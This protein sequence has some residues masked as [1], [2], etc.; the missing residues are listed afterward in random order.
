MRIQFHVDMDG[1]LWDA[2]D[3]NRSIIERESK[4]YSPA[5]SSM[6]DQERA[7]FWQNAWK[8]Y[9]GKTESQFHQ[10]LNLQN[11]TAEEFEELC[12]NQWGNHLDDVRVNVE[13]LHFLTNQTLDGHKI[14]IVTSS[15][16]EDVNHYL[17]LAE[18]YVENADSVFSSIVAS[19]DLH[20]Q[21]RKPS[22][23]PY[24]I[25]MKNMHEQNTGRT[26]HIGIEDSMNGA[27]SFLATAPS[28]ERNT[29]L[30]YLNETPYAGDDPRVISVKNITELARS[31]EQLARSLGRG[32]WEPSLSIA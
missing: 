27:T 5:L 11:I 15:R 20:P 19:D 3:R 29:Y 9:A 18:Q 32:N 25:S 16:R 7:A 8:D 14:G 31:F 10:I 2:E 23:V 28:N 4:Q 6:S 30:F 1:T 26:I 24:L 17:S 22:P 12:R 21:D 13:L